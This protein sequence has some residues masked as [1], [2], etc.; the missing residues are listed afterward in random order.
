MPI[1]KYVK[2]GAIVG[3]VMVKWDVREAVEE[4]SR[5][6]KEERGLTVV[7]GSLYA[8]ADLYRLPGT[9]PQF[10]TVLGNSSD[11]TYESGGVLTD[12]R[13][14]V[15]QQGT[16]ETTTS[17]TDLAVNGSGFFV[18]SG[19]SGSGGG[20]YLTRAG[21]FVAVASDTL[22]S[23]GARAV[24]AVLSE[25][26]APSWTTIVRTWSTCCARS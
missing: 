17:A 5:W 9:T 21:S 6:T 20:Q 7:A 25:M 22:V 14:G 12:I 8:V 19:G 3:T 24:S 26:T 23:D 10:E 18:V 1:P 2:K 15:A 4:V 11:G 13:Y 16:L